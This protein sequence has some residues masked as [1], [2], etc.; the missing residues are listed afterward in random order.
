L[1]L[2]LRESLHERDI[3]HHTKL[4]SLIIDQWREYYNALK[5]ELSSALGKI[6]FTADIWSSKG[7]H[8]YLALTAHWLSRNA[9]TGQV[10]LRQAL[11]AFRRIQGGHSGARIAR[12]VFHILES[13]EILHKVLFIIH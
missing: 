11:L 6:S 3:P 10:T 12:I 13:V 2:L 9:E 7:M 1:L 8:P 4:R 5:R